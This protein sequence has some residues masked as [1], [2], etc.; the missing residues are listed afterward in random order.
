MTAI[1]TAATVLAG[2]TLQACAESRTVVA[3]GKSAYSIYFDAKAPKSIRR[4]AL[5]LQ[6]VIEKATGVSCP[7]STRRPRR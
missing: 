7:W 4:A 5:E 6:R 3:D 2:F 1:L